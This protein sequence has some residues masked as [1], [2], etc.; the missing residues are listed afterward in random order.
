MSRVRK[1]SNT[2]Y[3]YYINLLGSDRKIF[4]WSDISYAMF[5]PRILHH[6][7]H[8]KD[9]PFADIMRDMQNIRVKI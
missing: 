4:K 8:W 7:R 2:C 6:D 3:W 1:M 5:Q 9:G